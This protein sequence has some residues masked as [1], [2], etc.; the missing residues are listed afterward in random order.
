MGTPTCCRRGRLPNQFTVGTTDAAES[1][2]SALALV[3]ATAW[4]VAQLAVTA[5]AARRH[6]YL[7]ALGTTELVVVR[8]L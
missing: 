8:G 5:A 6:E 4:D 1:A 2:V 3:G 7:V